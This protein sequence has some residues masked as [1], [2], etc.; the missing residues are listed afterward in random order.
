M[1]ICYRTHQRYNIKL[2]KR[3][4]AEFRNAIIKSQST[5]LPY[6]LQ[7]FPRGACG[8]ASLLLGKFYQEMEVGVPQYICGI[9]EDGHSH[10]WLQF[11]N[12]IIDITIDQFNDVNEQ[13]VVTTNNSW[14]SKFIPDIE[15]HPADF[16]EYDTSTRVSLRR[17]YNEI[18]CRLKP[19]YH[20][21]E[22][23]G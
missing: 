10:A 22:K 5:T 1:K 15:K 8:D 6:S 21:G 23:P 17:A 16:D 12:I 3:L 13:V 4:A 20:P 7:N 19:E 18:V 2:L 14:H 9:N 11:D